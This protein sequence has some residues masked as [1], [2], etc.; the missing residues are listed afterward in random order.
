[1]PRTALPPDILPRAEDFVDAF[2][3]CS[4]ERHLGMA[5][6]GP[7]P[8]SAVSRYADEMGYVGSDKRDLMEVIREMD[9]WWAARVA[10]SSKRS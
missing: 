2:L 9:N 10:E 1:M 8:R 4:T 3:E 5:G 6:P 7:I